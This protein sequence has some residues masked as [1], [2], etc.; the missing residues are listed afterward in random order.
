MTTTKIKT[1]FKTVLGFSDRHWLA[2]KKIDNKFFI[3]DS[4]R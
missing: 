3:L 2:V 1:F 4:K